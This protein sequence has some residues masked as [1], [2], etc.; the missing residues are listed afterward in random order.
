MTK[1]TLCEVVRGCPPL[2]S[3]WDRVVEC[4]GRSTVLENKKTQRVNV[5]AFAADD[6]N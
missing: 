1:K 4:V 3:R 2:L 5:V 6:N